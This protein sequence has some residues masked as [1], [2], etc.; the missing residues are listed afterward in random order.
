M[1]SCTTRVWTRAFPLESFRTPHH[2]SGQ[3]QTRMCKTARRPNQAVLRAVV[4]SILFLEDIAWSSHWLL[5][6][7]SHAIART[8]DAHRMVSQG[9]QMNR[10]VEFVVGTP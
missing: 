6:S 5:F 10:C 3:S 4:N 8:L 7:I 2:S 9:R 1:S